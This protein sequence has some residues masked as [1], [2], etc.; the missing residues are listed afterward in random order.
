MFLKGKTAQVLVENVDG[1]SDGERADERPEELL[2]TL[3][4]AS[5][6]AGIILLRQGFFAIHRDAI[7]I[8]SP[9]SGPVIARGD[10]GFLLSVGQS[11]PVCD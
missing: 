9:F 4:P 1:Q 6:P 5:P 8:L 3:H 11:L 7:L 2:Q 10:A